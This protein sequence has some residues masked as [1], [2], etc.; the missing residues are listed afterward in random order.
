MTGVAPRPRLLIVAETLRGGL[1]GVVREQAEWFTERGWSVA[2]A[3]PLE[4][5]ARASAGLRHHLVAIPTSARSLRSMALAIRS[6]RT[7]IRT[8]TPTVIHCHGLRSFAIARLA[9][10]MK[11]YVTLHGTGRVQ[12]DPFGY[13]GVRRL[14][15]RVAPPLAEVAFNAGPEQRRGW[16]FV[17]H[18]SPR[19]ATMAPLPFPPAGSEPV[20]LWLGRLSDPKLPELF[21]EAISEAARQHPLRG[22]LAGDGPLSE[23]VE[24]R[25]RELDAPIDVVGHSDDVAGLI[26]QSWALVLFSR[27]EALAFSAQEAMWAGRAVVSSPLQGIRWLVGDDG[28]VAGDVPTAVDR[29]VRLTDRDVASRL[30]AEAAVRV[31]KLIAPGSPWPAIEAAYRTR[32]DGRN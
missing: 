31:R 22:L 26:E 29:I 27:F 24:R 10:S 14:A 17:P 12:S 30:G 16:I 2:L 7:V 11:P 8:E 1:G 13:G 4:A 5:D 32:L 20:F 28:L 9:S 19:L 18:A 3:A 15:L 25:I 21:V 6:L 23:G